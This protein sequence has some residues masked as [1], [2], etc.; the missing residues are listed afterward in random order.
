MIKIGITGGIGSGKSTVCRIFSLL[1]VPVYDSDS[2]A[3]RLMNAD[4]EVTARIRSLFG[5]GAYRD[6]ELDRR[7]LASRIFADGKL[8]GE[9]NRIVHPA[10]SRDF[11][12]WAQRQR[13]PYVLQEAAILFESGA[14]R[15]MDAVVAV[16]A[17]EPV[18]I[19]R[20]MRRDSSS[21]EA[22]RA[23][24]AAQIGEA[25]R[26]ER[27]DYVI[28]ADDRELVVPQVLSLHERFCRL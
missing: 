19:R 21:E 8:R 22:V 2:N 11:L 24:M 4:P 15:D 27:A 16:S 17:P 26:V 12:D 18:R 14:W 25:E 10:V 5:E 1:G 20:A 9:L 23:R 7:L 6:G 28:L 3:R 13:G